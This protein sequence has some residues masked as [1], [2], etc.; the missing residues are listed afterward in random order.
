MDSKQFQAK[1]PKSQEDAI[2]EVLLTFKEKKV[3]NEKRLRCAEFYDLP[4]MLKP[5]CFYANS[6]KEELVLEHVKEF[7]KHFPLVFRDLEE[8]ELYLFPPNECGL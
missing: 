7:A 5:H 2:Q 3:I 8:R 1:K 4:E 6:P